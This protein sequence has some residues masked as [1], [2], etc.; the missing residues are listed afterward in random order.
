MWCSASVRMHAE[1]TLGCVVAI[2]RLVNCLE[3]GEELIE[4]VPNQ[5]HSFGLWEQGRFAWAIDLV[6]PLT[7]PIPA[8]GAQ[9][10][11]I[12]SDELIAAVDGR[13]DSG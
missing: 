2:G 3:I 12:P 10:L 5:E 8:V 13:S 4:A 9:R 7:L 6:K 11:W 1:N